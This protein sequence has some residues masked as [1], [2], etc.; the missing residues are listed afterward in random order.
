MTARDGVLLGSD[1]LIGLE[2]GK[3]QV[4]IEGGDWRGGS[5]ICH[6]LS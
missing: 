4:L 3:G 2:R 1:E 5:F 6:N